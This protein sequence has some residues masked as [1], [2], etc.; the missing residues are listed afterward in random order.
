V[1]SKTASGVIL[2]SR[3]VYPDEELPA[4]KLPESNCFFAVRRI[5]MLRG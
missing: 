5:A 3:E 1:K 4:P 2:I